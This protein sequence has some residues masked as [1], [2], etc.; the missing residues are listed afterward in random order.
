MPRTRIVLAAIVR[1]P[2]LRFFRS[3]ISHR[4]A[5]IDAPCGSL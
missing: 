1:F 2:A 5:Q 4:V 3:R